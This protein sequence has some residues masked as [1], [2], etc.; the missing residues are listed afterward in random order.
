M[1]LSLCTRRTERILPVAIISDRLLGEG[2]GKAQHDLPWLR[3]HS[4]ILYDY[5]T[6]GAG[7]TTCV[8]EHR[9]LFP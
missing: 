6:L 2:S 3:L 9:S 7:D 8:D 1:G 5:D 4:L